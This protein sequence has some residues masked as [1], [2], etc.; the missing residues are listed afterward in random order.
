[1][2]PWIVLGGVVLLALV[3]VVLPVV[4]A[5]W[6]YFRSLRRVRCPEAGADADIAVLAGR[7]AFT[8]AYTHPPR[9]RI[10]RCSLWPERQACAEACLDPVRTAAAAAAARP[11]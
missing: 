10:A 3:F 2:N 1:M 5:T 9:A 6:S 4:S 7:A 11:A 8:A